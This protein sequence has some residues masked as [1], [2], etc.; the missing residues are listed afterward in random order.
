[1][2]SVLNI[3][4]EHSVKLNDFNAFLARGREPEGDFGTSGEGLQ[5]SLRAKIEDCRQHHILLFS[6]LLD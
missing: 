3:P 2:V 5:A 1:M 6:K 4:V